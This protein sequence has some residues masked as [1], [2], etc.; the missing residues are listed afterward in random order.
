MATHTLLLN[1][2]Y[3]PMGVIPWQRAVSLMLGDKVVVLESYDSECR[4][5]GFCIKIPA[6]I[7]LKR[8]VKVRPKV[9]FS[10]KNLY[11]RDNF[12]C[13]YCGVHANKLK[14]RVQDIN[15]DHVLPRSRGG[16]TEW[17]NIVTACIDCNSKKANRT[18]QEAGLKLLRLPVEPKFHTMLSVPLGTPST[19][20]EWKSYLY[21]NVELEQS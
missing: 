11:M 12:T 19:P 14:Y 9:K 13:Q 3:E 17:T 5:V 6:V 21:W 15:L 16:K 4:S 7:C 20:K 1:G 18:P 10:R 2:S 8:Y